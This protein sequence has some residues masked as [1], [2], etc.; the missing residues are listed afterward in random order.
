M[1]VAETTAASNSRSKHLFIHGI[2]SFTVH[3]LSSSRVLKTINWIL[4]RIK[5]LKGKLL[6]RTKP[7]YTRSKLIHKL[8]SCAT[9][10]GSLTKWLGRRTWNPDIGGSSPSMTT[11]QELCLARPLV[12]LLSPESKVWCASLQL[13]FLSQLSLFEISI[14]V[15]QLVFPRTSW[16]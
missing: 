16:V 15:L 3:A 1:L 2:K 11:R 7:R 9:G 12:Q 6:Q 10:G 14:S 4:K 8:L 5:L 13:E